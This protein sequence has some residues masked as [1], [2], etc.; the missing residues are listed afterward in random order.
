MLNADE[1]SIA[2][3]RIIFCSG[4][5]QVVNALTLW[6]VFKAKLDPTDAT[7]VGSSLLGFFK[8]IETLAAENHQQAVILSGMIF[9]LV[10]WV[11]Q[12]LGFM[13]A[14]ILYLLFL[15]HYI[16]NADGGLRGYC[17]RKVNQQLSKIVSVK[18]NKAIEEEERKRRKAEAKALK[19]G[20]P[21]LGRQATLPT[22]LDQKSDSDSLPAMPMLSRNDTMTTL[23][24][25]TSR[26][27]TPSGQPTL[28]PL[29]MDQ[30]EKKPLPSRANTAAS[31]YSAN[32]SLLGN[33]S[34]MGYSSSQA[35]LPPLDTRGPLPG[36]QRSMT[37]TSSS[38][39]WQRGPPNDMSGRS[40]LGPN[41]EFTQSPM[42]YADDR[43]Q[44]GMSPANA[45]PYR[46]PG[47]QDTMD[48][49]GRPVRRP[50]GEMNGRPMAPGTPFS[51]ASQ[52]DASE[53]YGNRPVPQAVSEL[54]GRSITP[55]AQSMGRRTPFDPNY[56][57]GRSSPAPPAPG[58]GSDM[59]RSFSPAPTQGGRASP[60]P[61]QRGQ[62]A[63][64]PNRPF[65]PANNG[66]PAKYQPYQPYSS[67][68]RNV[69][70]S[71]SSPSPYSRS[72]PQ[73]TR[74]M[75]DPGSY[76][77]PGGEQFGEI[78]SPPRA[79][80]AQRRYTPPGVLDGPPPARTGSPATFGNVNGRQS[81][82]PYGASPRQGPPRGED[83]DPYRP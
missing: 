5:R 14:V 57:G 24:Q 10:I 30:L 12:A 37:G 41:R 23:P 2:W 71:P 75:T 83:Y 66:Q 55:G 42:S 6:S 69:S 26:P 38:G 35:P 8:N 79:N 72:P 48:S 74:N 59:G 13:L 77:R 46:G 76:P 17:E 4:P 68:L 20:V 18:V 61:S 58:P 16:P 34:D 70:A 7:D 43:S 62:P 64:G 33:A 29:E 31:K 9:T 63:A 3:I 80:T 50:T 82:A 51:S 81:P 47:R 1:L 45:G 21:P 54:S 60:A 28:P 15:W 78:S 44:A 32:A 49:Y 27:G 22:F 40:I 19:N 11:L 36:P 52:Q 73:Q 53:G 67:N 56:P 25:Y 65:S 39:P